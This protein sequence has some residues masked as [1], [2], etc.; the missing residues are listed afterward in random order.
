MRNSPSLAL[1]LL[2]LTSAFAASNTPAPNW[3]QFRGVNSSGVAS[4]A[5]PP[6][7]IGPAEGILWSVEVPWSPSS[8]S[9]W[10]NRI[11]LTTYHEGQLE[12]RCYDR[13]DGRLLW[14][15]A[16]KP[17]S[18]EDHHRSDGSPAA[19]T[20]ATDGRRVV[21]YFGSFGVICHDFDGRELWRHPLPTALS[22]GRF[23][24]GTSPVIFGDRVIINRDQYQYSSLL[25]LDV[26]TGRTIWDTARPESAGSFG[27]PVLWHNAGVDELVFAGTAQLKA[28]ELK[29]GVERW[30]IPGV[31]GTVCTTAV[32]GDGLLFF[33]AWSPGQADSPRQS[34]E[35]FLKRND[36]NGDG[37]VDLE[38]I[39]ISRRDY[40]RGMDRTR[41][42]RFTRVDW[43]LLKS[44]D[45]RADNLLLAIKPGGQGDISESHV[46]WKYRRALPYVPSPLYYDGRIYL[47]KDGGLMSS[48]DAKTGEA[49][50]A[51]ERI[52][53]NGNYYASPVA[54]DGRIYVASLPGKLTVVKA[55]GV[56]PEILHQ[57]DFGTRIL[58]TPALVGENLYLRTATHLWAF[59]KKDGG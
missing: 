51:Q 34:W 10:G 5:R 20:P 44:G 9:V 17:E 22:G 6:V 58:A 47:V 33:G 39:D 40:I 3:P 11:F 18:L 36:K 27:T 56:K 42:G 57:V 23:G 38:E 12:T 59:G 8:P 25:A 37:V 15:R 50:Y 28:Y 1:L 13:T 14:S 35:E 48:L 32:I 46:A 45:A 4:D 43:D 49:F 41:D 19:S 55:G 21:S 16:V 7:K 24:S 52:G 31:T 26:A 30:V 54:A 53:A 29:T 2:G